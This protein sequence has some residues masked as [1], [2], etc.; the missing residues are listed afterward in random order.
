MDNSSGK[1]II[2]MRTIAGITQAPLARKAGID[3]SRLSEIENSRKSPTIDELIKLAEALECKP[4]KLLP[5][6]ILTAIQEEVIENQANISSNRKE[7]KKIW[8]AIN[9]LRKC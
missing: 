2:I 7:I 3:T 9:E 1:N 5:S 6:T 4:H 8:E